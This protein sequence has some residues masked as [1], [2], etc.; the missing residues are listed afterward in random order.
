MAWNTVGGDLYEAL[1]T[2][3][4]AAFR[5][6]QQP[7]LDLLWYLWCG[8]LSPL[9]GKDKIATFEMYFVADKATHQGDEESLLQAHPRERASA[10]ASWKI[11]GWMPSTG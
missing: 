1:N 5:E 9:F 4:H 7:H 6:R 10:A 3:I 11:S 8:P 2:A